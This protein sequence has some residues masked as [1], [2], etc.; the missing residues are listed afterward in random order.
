MGLVYRDADLDKFPQVKKQDSK[1]ISLG[2]LHGNAL[3]LIYILV[4]EGVLQLNEAA[5]NS[6]RDIYNTNVNDLTA[7]QLS[8]FQT[9]IAAADVNLDKAVT[10]IGDELADRGNNDYF[11][12][13]VLKKLHESKLNLDIILSNHSAEFIRDYANVQFTGFYNLSIGQGQSLARMQFLIGK[14]LVKE[15]EVRSIVRDCYIPK[16]KALSYTVSPEGELT[17]FSHAPIGLETIQGLAKKFDLPYHD[18]TT[19]ELIQTI[20]RINKKIETLFITHVTHG[21]F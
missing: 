14:G 9:I 19:K 8:S 5:Y 11:T 2:D 21:Q 15:E 17:L 18:K 3:K 7:E 16:A 1:H 20:D 13:L 6:L 4:E 12:L 10:L